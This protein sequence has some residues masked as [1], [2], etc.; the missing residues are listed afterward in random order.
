MHKT[1]ILSFPYFEYSLFVPARIPYRR[2]KRICH[3]LN[4]IKMVQL[5]NGIGKR[6]AVACQFPLY[7]FHQ[8]Y[9]LCGIGNFHHRIV[10]CVIVGFYAVNTI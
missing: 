4:T 2:N 1:S 10:Q 8:S 9:A 5:L 7:G 6:A 3:F